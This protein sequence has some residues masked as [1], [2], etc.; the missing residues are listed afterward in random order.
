MVIGGVYGR[1]VGI[2]HI[3]IT[4]V[5]AIITLFQ[6]F[7]LMLTRVGEATIETMTGTVTVGT[8][9]GFLIDNFNRTGR[10][11]IAID[12]GKSKGPGAS[13]ATNLDRN[14]RYRN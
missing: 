11:G 1:G 9:N 2:V 10:V 5:G 14:N 8:M 6:V 3:I 4:G 12:T 7:I 13:R